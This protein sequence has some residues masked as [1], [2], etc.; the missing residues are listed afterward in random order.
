M[1]GK[2]SLSEKIEQDKL[3]VPTS[4]KYRKSLQAEFL[5]INIPMRSVTQQ[6]FKV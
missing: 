2:R 3:T 4:K 1:S 5:F 6:Y